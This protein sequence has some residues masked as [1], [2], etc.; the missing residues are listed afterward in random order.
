MVR[1]ALQLW[2]VRLAIVFTIL[3][4]T[5][6]IFRVETV[7]IDPSIIVAIIITLGALT[8]AFF[9]FKSSWNKQRED[10]ATALSKDF[11]IA[12]QKER[13][14]RD[15]SIDEGLS[16]LAKDIGNINTLL[17]ENKIDDVEHKTDYKSFKET[18]HNRL[19]KI[20]KK[21]FR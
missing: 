21:I 8:Q 19:E 5:L 14:K 9:S 11:E 10:K 13:D 4:T 18:T 12:K 16:Q 20:E 6:I 2:K 17:E 1:F 7:K 15:K 3:T